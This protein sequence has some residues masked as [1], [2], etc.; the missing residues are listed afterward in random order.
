MAKELL[1]DI[2]LLVNGV[3]LT[4]QARSFEAPNDADA[5]EV[6]TFGQSRFKEYLPGMADAQVTVGFLNDHSTGSVADTLQPLAQTGG[7]FALKWWP[8]RA[9]TVVYTMTA[10]LLSYPTMA[11]AVGEAN[12]F[13]A[14]FINGGTAGIT[15]GTA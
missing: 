6:T 14:V 7:T 13:D 8:D 1:R 9:G 5:V 11:G 3:D 15:R 2:K 10:R 12:A 4:T